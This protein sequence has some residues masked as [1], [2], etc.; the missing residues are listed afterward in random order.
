MLL[1]R[2]CPMYTTQMQKFTFNYPAKHS[3]AA[4]CCL[5]CSAP[6]QMCAPIR[7]M[8]TWENH[9]EQQCVATAIFKLCWFLLSKHLLLLLLLRILYHSAWL[10]KSPAPPQKH[11]GNKQNKLTWRYTPKETLRQSLMSQN[12][13]GTFLNV[14]GSLSYNAWSQPWTIL[15]SVWCHLLGSNF[16]PIPLL[17]MEPMALMPLLLLPFR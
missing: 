17:P 12:C 13:I 4:G 5:F 8:K 15:W 10:L 9:A 1:Q 6:P 3:N 16:K 14:D 2:A 7:L 11:D